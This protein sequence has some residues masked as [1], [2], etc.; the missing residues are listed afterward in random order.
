MNKTLTPNQGQQAAIDNFF[1]FMI[2][3]SKY[4]HLRGPAGVGKTFVMQLLAN[5]GMKEYEDGCKLAGLEQTVKDVVFTA[6]TNKA[7]EVLSQAIHKPALTIHSHLCLKVYENHN[8]GETTLEKRPDYYIHQNELVFIDECSM[9]DSK[10][11]NIIKT[12][13][14]NS[15]IVFV[16]DHNQ[17]APVFEKLSPIYNEDGFISDLV[18]PV[19]NAGQPALMALCNQLR[20]TVATG[21]FKPIQEVPGVIEYLD[22]KEMQQKLDTMFLD[23]DV[24]S[25]ILCYRNKQVKSFNDYIRLQVRQRGSRYEVGENLICASG[26]QP[27]TGPGLSIE[28][29]LEVTRVSEHTTEIEIKNAKFDTYMMTVK[30]QFESINLYVPTDQAHFD[31]VMDYFRKNKMW[32]EYFRMKNGYPD[33]RP[34]DAATIYKAQGS[35]YDSV[36][37]DLDDI[38]RCTQAD[39]VARMLYV[40][41]SRCRN[42]LYLYGK[43]KA[44]YRGG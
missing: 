37:L 8:T 43:L 14:L 28:Q 26:Y 27:R 1:R 6:T 41:A 34:R 9:I 3:P 7:A 4:M 39:Q 25:R 18:E 11:W 42:K 35:T 16:G 29:A 32:P 20:D 36:F 15:K 5:Q 17:M 13:F 31:A 19:R 24:D 30:T 23:E 2:S 12:S 33:L 10:L 44:A 38:S 40:G 21:I 22:G